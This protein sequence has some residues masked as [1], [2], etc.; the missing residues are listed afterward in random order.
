MSEA[1]LK[2][3]VTLFPGAGKDP[4]ILGYHNVVEPG[5]AKKGFEV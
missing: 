4:F 1:V 3:N 5:A 2:R